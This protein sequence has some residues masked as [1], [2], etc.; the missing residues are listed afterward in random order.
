MATFEAT[1]DALCEALVEDKLS[2]VQSDPD[3][4]RELVSDGFEGFTKMSAR[5]LVQCA[6]DA[7]L[8]FRSPTVAE[9]IHTLE[10]F[11]T[12]R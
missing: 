3:L 10:Q 2:Q 6:K 11:D 7:G 8:E 1:F 12:S 4:L 9:H 5:E